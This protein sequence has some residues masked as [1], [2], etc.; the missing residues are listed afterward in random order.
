MVRSMG[1][2]GAVVAVLAALCAPTARAQSF[3]GGLSVWVPWDLFEGETASVS[4]ESS[5]ETSFGLGDFLTF[6]IGVAYNQ[7]Y[8]SSPIGTVDDDKNF[9]TSGPWF[10]SDSLTPYLAAQVR[11]PLGP[12]FIDLFGGG[13]LNWNITLRPFPDRI[14]RDLRDAG[15]LD[16]ALT[17]GNVALSSLEIDSG[18]GVGW[19]AG[20]A[21]GLSFGDIS[22]NLNATYRR[23]AHDLTITGRYWYESGASGTLDSSD[24]AFV[25]EELRVLM[26]GIS[27]GVGGSYAM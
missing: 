16:P 14:A 13:V 1:R 22:V 26:H 7:I 11:I 6:P 10:Y 19:L 24:D 20:T 15:A 27:I 21:V 5:L 25:V 3:G 2:V 12:A 18:V 9:K 23:V 8:G 17:D 4:I